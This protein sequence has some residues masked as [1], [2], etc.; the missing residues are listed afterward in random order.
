M[1]NNW[2]DTYYSYRTATNTSTISN[3]DAVALE[4]MRRDMRN[5]GYL[6]TD[7][8]NLRVVTDPAVIESVGTVGTTSSDIWFVNREFMGQ[9]TSY[10]EYL[11]FNKDT[12]AMGA[13]RTM[14]N[15]NK[16]KVTD[17]GRFLVWGNTE[18]TC[19]RT[20]MVYRSRL[21]IDAPFL[22]AVMTNVEYSPDQVI[23]ETPFPGDAGYLNGGVT[24]PY[25]GADGTV[26]NITVCTDNAA[27]ILDFT[28][29]EAFSCTEGGTVNVIVEGTTIPGVVTG[30]GTTAITVDFTDG[31]VTPAFYATLVCADFTFVGGQVVCPYQVQ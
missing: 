25:Q 14:L 6:I 21:R 7:R 13:Y 22:C 17:G 19:I 23:Q 16:F 9:R 30:V 2:P 10:V 26:V 27:G 20:N 3:L 12:T 31:A 24:G 8:G 5:S 18:G 11:P 15:E 28:V 4:N 1:V 29:D